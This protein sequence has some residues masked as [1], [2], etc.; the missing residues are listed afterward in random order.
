[1]VDERA[2][3]IRGADY[4]Q[5]EKQSNYGIFYV[6]FS[7]SFG[8]VQA[9]AGLHSPVNVLSDDSVALVVQLVLQFPNQLK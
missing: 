6:H 9:D 4:R 1:V 5:R 2:H 3:R 8:L 7:I